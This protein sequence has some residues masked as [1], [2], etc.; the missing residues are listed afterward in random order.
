VR[1][2]AIALSTAT[3]LLA[4]TGLLAVDLWRWHAQT[5]KAAEARALTLSHVLA[6]YVRETFSAG[7]AALRQLAIHSLRV[8][9]P[10]AP[11]S[12]WTAAIEAADASMSTIGFISVVDRHGIIRHS[13]EHV[14]VGQSRESDLI[15]QRL[16]SVS[17]DELAIDVPLPSARQPSD[18]FIPLGRRLVDNEGRFA[19][20]IVAMFMPA[21]LRSFFQTVGAG[22]QGVVW[23]FHPDG[24]VVLREPAADS[25]GGSTVRG[26]P[27]FD[28][29]STGVASGTL[30][31]LAG[32]DGRAAI[33]AFRR[34]SEPPLVVAVS[35]DRDEVLA[36]WRQI[37][38]GSLS[39]FAMSSVLLLAVTFGLFR[40]M[41]AKARA[42]MALGD[43]QRVENER[44]QAT[45]RL[46]TASLDR[47][48]AA[49]Q[50]A[51]A[52][53]AVKDQFLMTVSHELRTPLTAIYGW[54]RMLAAGTV[55]GPQRDS[56]VRTIVRNARAQMRIID[57][58]LDASQVMNG[59]LRLDLRPIDAARAVG[60][61]VDSM[62][63]AADAK[64]I[65]LH[66]SV[67]ATPCELVA[68]GDR[69]QQI[70]WN[71]VSNA[72]K[73]T[74]PG[75]SVSVRVQAAGGAG[76]VEIVVSDTRCGI[77]SDFLPHVFDRFRQQDGGTKRRHGGLGLGL[78]IVRSLVDLHGGTVL[79]AS[80]GEGRGATFTVRLPI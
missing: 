69:L 74:P 3:I 42:E 45:N 8:G 47:E 30:R 11:D 9:G 32:L 73:F 46:L 61:A 80:E 77:S 55:G 36:E 40:Q 72:V 25:L 49:R 59:T 43:A 19:G 64:S 53:N 1:K 26:N 7:D 27:I 20:A 68:D 2:V 71:L 13:T 6:A 66:V 16:R 17:R 5:L 35:L 28:A 50:E 4:L 63:P 60:D 75:G 41:D 12:E 65:A 21:E 14:L 38:L 22:Q 67:D 54:A 56:A 31:G 79:A 18:Y 29:A 78:A 10:D 37:A 48:Q 57:D 58:L 34:T 70:V 51:E 52:A 39:F 24:M 33:S 15:F 62:R 44:L 23:V 76:A